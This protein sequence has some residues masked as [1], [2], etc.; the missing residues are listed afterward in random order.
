MKI[1]IA[2]G[3]E[4]QSVNIPDNNLKAILKSNPIAVV[5]QGGNAVCAALLNPIGTL[6]L[7]DIVKQGEKIVIITSD[8]T[9]PLPSHLV[10][11]PILDELKKN[12]INNDDITIVFALGGHRKHTD[13]EMKELLGKSIYSTIRCVDG[14]SKDCINMGKT[15]HGTP[16]DV[17]RIVAEADRRICVGNIEYHYFAG[18]SGG[19]KAIMPGVSTREAIQINHSC[20]VDPLAVAGRIDNNPVRQDLEEAIKYCPIDFIVNVILDEKKNVIHAVAGH[21]IKAHRQ[22]CQFLDKLYSKPIDELA[23]IV[24]VSQGGTPKDLNLYQTQK[25]L[26]NAKHAVRDGG[27]IILVGSCEEGFGEEVFEDWLLTATDPKSL[28]KRIKNNFKLGGHKAAAI[29]MVLEK[30]DIFF[31][32]KMEEE[33]VRSA[34][35]Q[36]FTTVQEALNEAFNQLGHKAKV[37][38][39]PHGGSTLPILENKN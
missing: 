32:S 36:P 7:K 34:F 14:D 21:Y 30:N 28:I 38:V 1:D 3:K 33:M 11:P 12:D 23:D 15:K 25:A 4:K 13:E 20:M 31:V 10:L 35:M 17:T 9:R 19:A 22:G 6:S 5:N 2:I 26:D 8:L 18:Y 37:I 24:I 39:M 29:A 16:V 27:I